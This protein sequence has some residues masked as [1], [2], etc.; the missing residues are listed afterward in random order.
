MS[1]GSVNLSTR[2]MNSIHSTTP[3][4]T[5]STQATHTTNNVHKLP[6]NAHASSKPG[7]STPGLPPRPPRQGH[8]AAESS[9]TSIAPRSTSP[10]LRRQLIEPDHVADKGC[11]SS[12]S[13]SEV[14]D[15]SEYQTA[16][17]DLNRSNI[18]AGLS[19]EWLLQNGRGN[20]SSRLESMAPGS[21]IHS[22]AADRQAQY[23]DALSSAYRSGDEEPIKT[24]SRALISSAGL[25][26]IGSSS[27]IY[28]SPYRGLGAVADEIS[29]IIR[30]I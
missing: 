23:H 4:S 28:C 30:G 3:R 14:R 18:C 7:L 22:R 2:N 17:A 8:Q 13:S 6:G 10:L 11:G 15:I 25:H 1:V 19:A 27:T 21:G 20:A 5:P 9:K 29:K 12:S 24:A 16:S 26:Q